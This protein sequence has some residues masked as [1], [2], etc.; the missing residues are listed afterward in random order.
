MSCYHPRCLLSRGDAAFI[1]YMQSLKL[2][3]SALDRFADRFV[4]TLK[5]VI[6]KPPTRKTC[7]GRR[8][9]SEA[10]ELS[11]VGQRLASRKDA[12]FERER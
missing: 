5:R 9:N 10:Y 3:I 2:E 12:T 1:V 4:E 6:F 8:P 11:I 7:H